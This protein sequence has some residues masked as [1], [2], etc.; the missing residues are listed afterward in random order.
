MSRPLSL[1]EV[2][3]AEMETIRN[4]LGVLNI[5][6]RSRPKKAGHVKNGRDM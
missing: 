6:L 3:L 4:A 5:Y 1:D 2:T